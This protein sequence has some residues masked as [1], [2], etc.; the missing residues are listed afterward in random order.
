MNRG[1]VAEIDLSAIAHNLETLKKITKNRTVIAVVKADAYG[2]GSIEVSKRLIQEGVSYLAVAYTGEAIHIRNAGITAPIIVLF[3]CQDIEDF[4]DFN[5]IPVIHDITTALAI[6]RKAIEKKRK[7]KIHVKIDTGMGRLGLSSDHIIEDLLN[8]AD[9]E[10]IEL[11]GLMSHFSDADLSDRSYASVQ[12]ERFNK[13]RETLFKKLN[14]KIFSHIANSAAVLTFKDA[15]LDAVRPGL[16]LYGYSPMS[17]NAKCG[18]RSAELYSEL[19]TPNSELQDLIPAMRVKTNV[20][21]IRYLPS[22]F[23]I[24]YGRSFVTKRQS[25]IGVL[26]IGYADGYNRLFSNNAEVLV[27]ARRVPVAGRVCMDLT[28]VDLTEVID[29]KEGDEVV[30]LGQQ[31]N[32]SI[33]AYELADKAGTI[34]YEI[35]TSLGSYSRKEYIN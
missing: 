31:G 6:S 30:I 24:S 23:P 3:D 4:F 28:M 15:H 20:L 8:I 16:M 1:A 34:P 7:L 11:S 2:H 26:P 13:I 18:M 33:T 9:M 22:N 27:G 5:L 17:K 14:Q 10:G 25:K 12:L 29:V 32:E 35:L 19:Q 21:S